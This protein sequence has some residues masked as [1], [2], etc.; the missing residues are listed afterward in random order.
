MS[1]QE[2]VN[3]EQSQES[4]QT[5]EANSNQE[6][7]SVPLAEFLK[8]KEELKGFKKEKETFELEKK[9]ASE[10][11]LIEEKRYEELL[12]QRE[13]ELSAIKSE[14]EA[15]VKN[16][17]I[18]GFKNKAINELYKLNAHDAQDA[19]K[20]MDFEGLLDAE[21]ADNLINEQIDKLKEG[22]S[23]LFNSVEP[24]KRSASEN[25]IPSASSGQPKQNN[26]NKTLSARDR[27]VMSLASKHK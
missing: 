4:N 23:Y 7:K 13:D 20:F 2:N 12:K 22:K 17:K 5:Q 15:L 16:N 9:K 3:Q 18:D 11:K 1:E 10:A 14:K 26:D 25:G 24:K 19:L 8:I 21:D 27:I 6:N